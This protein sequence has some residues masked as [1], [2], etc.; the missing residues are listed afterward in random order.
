MS[1]IVA[2]VTLTWT[3]DVANGRNIPVVAYWPM[4]ASMFTIGYHSDVLQKR[5]DIYVDISGATIFAF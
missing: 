2:D 5:Q 1:L 4:S 3:L